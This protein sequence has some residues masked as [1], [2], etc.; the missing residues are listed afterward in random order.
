[1]G[2][3][4]A[5]AGIGSAIL[6]KHTADKQART[7]A[8]ATDKAIA[9]QRLG[10]DYLK[11]NSNVNAAQQQGGQAQGIISGLLGLGGDQAAADKAFQTYQDSTGYQFRLGQGMD[12]ITG[13]RAARGLLD[14]GST[15]KALN[16]YGQGMGS[17]EFSNYLSQLTGQ[18]D[19]GLNAAYNVASQGQSAGSGIASA[20]QT[21]ANNMNAIRQS[22]AESIA[23][24]LSTA[25][26]G[27]G[28]IFAN[29]TAPTAYS[30]SGTGSWWG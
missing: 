20:V 13:S 3:V 26:S 12:A 14:S 16:D 11:G 7:Q 28:S 24:G 4:S 19:I 15:L 27:F 1:M 8:A 2:W 5:I 6:G 25:L 23:G 17:A 30:S 10:F 22:G 9:A 21:G 18:Q 29:R